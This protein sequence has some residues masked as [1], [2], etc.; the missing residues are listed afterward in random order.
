MKF[1]RI[2]YEVYA[3]QWNGDNIEEIREIFSHLKEDTRQ[4]E[5]SVRPSSRIM[6]EDS[7]SPFIVTGDLGMWIVVIPHFAMFDV[8]DDEDMRDEYEPA[9]E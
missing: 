9:K 3:E 2:A 5:F 1:K 8:L 4:F 6:I 7:Q